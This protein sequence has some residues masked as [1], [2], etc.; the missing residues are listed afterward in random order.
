MCDIMEKLMEEQSR[1]DRIDLARVAI[2][3]GKLSYAE[4]AEYYNLPLSTI[5]EMAAEQ[6]KS[7]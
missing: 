1:N 7:V 4:V 2:T 6:K 5:E 3:K